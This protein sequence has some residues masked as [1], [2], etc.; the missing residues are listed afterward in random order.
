MIKSRKATTVATLVVTAT[1]GM[2][3]LSACGSNTAAETTPSP[4]DTREAGAFG[5]K[6]VHLKLVNQTGQNLEINELAVTYHVKKTGGKIT[7][8]TYAEVKGSK[9]LQPGAST[10]D[11]GQRASFAVLGSKAGTIDSFTAG[12]PP[13]GY[14][15]IQY[16]ASDPD[17]G[18]W[19]K[20]SLGENEDF[21]WTSPTTG[22][23]YDIKRG[24]DSD[25]KEFT[26]TV[27]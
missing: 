12:N 18:K 10:D 1:A 5:T 26:I 6:D 9:N 3:L 21:T 15:F 22:R 17:K 8:N 27:R 7:S 25:Y 20:K 4:T 11:T 23:S 14:P 2:G 19:D 24:N 16:K 13:D